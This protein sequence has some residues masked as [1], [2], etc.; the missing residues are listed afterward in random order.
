MKGR[1]PSLTNTLDSRKVFEFLEPMVLPFIITTPE[2][3]RGRVK[4]P[5]RRGSRIRSRDCYE[6]T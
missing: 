5:R 2:R 3:L 4:S 6:D 1:S